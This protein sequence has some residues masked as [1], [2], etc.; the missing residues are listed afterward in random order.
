[1]TTSTPGAY[2]DALPIWAKQIESARRQT[3]AAVVALS[4][5]FE[6]IVNRLDRA[7]GAGG[8]HSGNE[9][10]AEDARQ[11]AISRLSR[12]QH[13]LTALP[14]VCPGVVIVQHMPPTFTAAF[15]QRL[16]GLCRITV[17]EAR[18]NAG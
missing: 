3:E 5:R 14:L 8:S 18:T 6:G 2:A 7:L 17:K 11:G 10:I 15:A 9:S 13:V 1:L 4:A 16:D 12:I